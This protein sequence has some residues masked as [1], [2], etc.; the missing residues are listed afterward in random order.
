[1]IVDVPAIAGAKASLA[2]DTRPMWQNLRPGTV[3]ADH[4]PKTGRIA[5]D[6]RHDSSPGETSATK[7]PRTGHCGPRVKHPPTLRPRDGSV[8]AYSA[9]TGTGF[10]I[11]TPM[12]LPYSVHDPS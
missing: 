5:R 7:P 1:M 2:D 3:M 4:D 11:G 8:S 10:S 12:R 6:P 9:A